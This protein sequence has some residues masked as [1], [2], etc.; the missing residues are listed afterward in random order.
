MTD[1]KM[2]SL[3]GDDISDPK[4]KLL[5]DAV[6]VSERDLQVIEED[7]TTHDYGPARQRFDYNGLL[8]HIHSIII[9]ANNI[10]RN[11]AEPH[12]AGKE[13]RFKGQAQTSFL[14]RAG[15]E[16]KDR[17]LRYMDACESAIGK[18]TLALRRN[19]YTQRKWRQRL[20]ISTT[21]GQSRRHEKQV[22]DTD[23]ARLRASTLASPI[24]PVVTNA[25]LLSNDGSANKTD[26]QSQ[27]LQA[28]GLPQ[29]AH[30]GADTS[31]LMPGS[32]I[33]RP[34]TKRPPSP[35]SLS[36]VPKRIAENRP[37]HRT[38]SINVGNETELAALLTQHDEAN[39]WSR[40]YDDFLSACY[41][42]TSN[43][44]SLGE[45][46]PSLRARAGTL[47]TTARL[48]RQGLKGLI[49]Q[50]TA[51]IQDVTG[52]ESSLQPHQ[53]L[54]FQTLVEAEDAV[55]A[56]LS[57]SDLLTRMALFG[58]KAGRG[59]ALPRETDFTRGRMTYLPI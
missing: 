1:E 59:Y 32:S 5:F 7:I 52:G 55:A 16:Q 4:V 9:G 38:L 27:L 28:Q 22:G 10:L 54:G 29:L 45:S 50:T 42:T 26:K 8:D 17:L 6:V 31:P 48:W 11:L 19:Q 23:Y 37:A 36:P 12:D 34:R 40:R 41:A 33:I 21:Q 14:L 20:E 30:M 15:Y 57:T 46:L 2:I 44:T 18:P 43:S 56:V 51:G 25:D 39:S 35:S 13:S 58:H 47:S 3:R 24:Y 53:L 49:A